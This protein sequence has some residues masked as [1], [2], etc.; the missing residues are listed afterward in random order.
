MNHIHRLTQERDEAQDQVRQMEQELIDLQQYLGS[1]KFAG[2]D[3]DWVSAREMWRRV[4]E[5]RCN[6]WGTA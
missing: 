1:A 3:N 5:I 2:I 6:R 4:Q